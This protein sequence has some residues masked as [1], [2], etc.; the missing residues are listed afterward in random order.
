MD[1]E[2]ERRKQDV[3]E[4]QLRLQDAERILVRWCDVGVVRHKVSPEVVVCVI[5][6]SPAFPC[7][8]HGVCI[9]DMCGWSSSPSPL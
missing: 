7:V 8:Q 2:L 4:L 1:A 9:Y 3:R 5:A 6:S